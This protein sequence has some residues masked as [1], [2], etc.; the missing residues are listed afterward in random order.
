MAR[1]L[2]KDL[3]FSELLSTPG[4]EV[5]FAVGTTYS[6]SLD[7]L[8][9]VPI[10]FG[11][12]GELD[13]CAKNNPYYILESI[14]RS[15]DRFAIFC[16]KGGITVPH[17]VRNVYTLLEK[18]VFEVYDKDNQL[19]NFH[20]KVWVIREHSREDESKR[21]VKVII[22]SRNL[23]YDSSLDIVASLTAP[24]YRRHTQYM[25]KHRPLKSFLEWLASQKN[26]SKRAQILELAE[27]IDSLGEFQV[28]DPFCDYEF[29]PIQYGQNLNDAVDLDKAMSGR[30]MIAVSPFIDMATLKAL[31]DKRKNWKDGH[32]ILITRSD[33]VNQEVFDYYNDR[34]DDI[35]VV[36]DSMLDNEIAPINLHAKCYYVSEPKDSHPN[37]LYL[38]SANATQSAFH[39]NTEFMLRL[40]FIGGKHNVMSTVLSQFV[41]DEDKRFEKVI[42]P[43]TEGSE[44]VQYT[45]VD[46]LLIKASRAT[47]KAEAVET[48][49]GL[50]SITISTNTLPR[51]G[52]FYIAPLQLGRNRF[53]RI[54]DSVSFSGI[55]A[56]QLSE[57]YILKVVDPSVPEG[58][59]NREDS[60]IIKIKTKGLPDNL[61]TLIVQSII[62]TKEKFLDYVTM[63]LSDNPAELVFERQ[64]E[65]EIAGGSAAKGTS[66]PALYERLLR[67]AY[68]DPKQLKRIDN[69]VKEIKSDVVGDK[70]PKMYT[71]FLSI[72]KQLERL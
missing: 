25:V 41:N 11:M 40:E 21:Q 65:R 29:I 30:W 43:C 46:K 53:S 35:Y 23:T 66:Y 15:S 12:L 19:A 6:L 28:A 33:Y 31:N 8:L 72:L 44:K 7:A 10:S 1:E 58:E 55:H 48:P 27:D 69:F 52:E 67:V 32:S 64:T 14:R 9:S 62:D 51:G 59:D 71:K 42:R 68:D 2:M 56:E 24:L 4:Y 34:G 3:L 45:G 16:N 37:Y 13:D 61:D 26:C 39:R 20:P 18:S 17:D 49:D 38:G 36:N 5:E 57:F 60:A 54:C 22:M 70:F 63:M 47:F 50:Y